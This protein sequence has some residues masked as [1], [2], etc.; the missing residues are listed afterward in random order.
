MNERTQPIIS[1]VL[2]AYNEEGN[3]VICLRTAIAA[4]ERLTNGNWEIVVV[5]D[6][7]RDATATLVKKEFADEPR[8]R[9]ISHGKNLGYGRALTTGL[10]QSLGYW[11]FV[12]DSDMQF[13]FEELEL[14]LPFM[15]TSDVIQGFRIQ[16]ED[17]V[18]RIILGA[19]YRNLVHRLFRMPVRDPECSFRL[20]RRSTIETMPLVCHGPMVP[21]ELIFRAARGG[22][23]F[24]EVGV[25]HRLREAGIQSALSW[26]SVIRIVRDFASLSRVALSKSL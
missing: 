2:P 4:L 9:T 26:R 5:D 21:V 14:L 6:G 25:R 13:Y 18:F 10:S 22:A 19:A 23:R 17:P 7:S 11:I 12:T 8:V 15:E 20:I 1:A 3:I 24:Q 16:R